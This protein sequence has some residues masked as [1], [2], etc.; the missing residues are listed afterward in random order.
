MKNS[1]D[2]IEKVIVLKDIAEYLKD[3]SKAKD[4]DW[5]EWIQDANDLLIRCERLLKRN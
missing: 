5:F 4:E 1:N 3:F 2:E